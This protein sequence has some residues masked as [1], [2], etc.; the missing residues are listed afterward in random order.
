MQVKEKI[1]ME[2]KEVIFEQFESV[3]GETKSQARRYLEQHWL[4]IGCVVVPCVIL[5][6]AAFSAVTVK[7][8]RM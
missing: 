8:M 4:S 6:L 1:K 2:L 3:C 7:V 5:P